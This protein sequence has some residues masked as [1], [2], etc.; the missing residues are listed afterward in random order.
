[1]S[2]QSR[3]NNGVPKIFVLKCRSCCRTRLAKSVN[4]LEQRSE[5]ST[6]VNIEWM[7]RGPIKPSVSIRLKTVKEVGKRIAGLFNQVTAGKMF[8]IAI[9]IN[10]LQY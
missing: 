6:S 7:T 1:M 5:L 3:K 9:I 4:I 10:P 8:L 2:K